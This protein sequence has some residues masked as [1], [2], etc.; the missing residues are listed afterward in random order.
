MA[1][2]L[3]TTGAA[4]APEPAP[5][6]PEFAL[7]ALFGLY[8]YQLLTLLAGNQRAGALGHLAAAR[9]APGGQG[10]QARYH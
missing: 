8:K 10:R 2:M 1:V 9:S 7:G 6:T 5:F 4:P 3:A